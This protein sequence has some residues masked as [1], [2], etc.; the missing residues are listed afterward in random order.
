MNF[1][2]SSKI[3]SDKDLWFLQ[4]KL[5][6]KEIIRVQNLLTGKYLFEFSE[7]NLEKIAKLCNLNI[8]YETIH[9]KDY[10]KNILSF[11]NLEKI[12]YRKWE[13]PCLLAY[14]YYGNLQILKKPKIGIIGS[15]KPTFYG[16]KIASDFS[17]ELAIAGCTIIS[18]GAIGIDSIANAVAFEYGNTCA[19]IGSG[20][21]QLYPTSN[22]SL[23]NK[24]MCAE[25]SLLM[26]EFHQYCTPKKWN[27]PRRNISIAAICDFI[28]VV[29]AGKT[30]GSL[31]TANAAIDLGCNVG[32]I[33]GD[34]TSSNSEG[35]NQLIKNGAYCIQSPKDILEIINSL[36]YISR[37]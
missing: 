9:K 5:S 28:L 32:A 2:S 29:E 24:M 36:S 11:Q 35:C 14:Q 31:I 3:L 17:K 13:H 6:I 20:L 19:I 34:I 23:F 8:N 37:G 30:S 26:S 16:R 15:R 21:K 18:G 25:N 22:L 12:I 10:E 4:T 33:P 7:L 27:F 1:N